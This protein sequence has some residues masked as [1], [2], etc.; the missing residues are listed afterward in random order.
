M[1]KRIYNKIQREIY[2][3]KIRKIKGLSVGNGLK[4]V[5]LPIIDIRNGGKISIGSNV[6]LT[7]DNVGYHLNMYSPVKLYA[8]RPGAEIV[9]G[10]NTRI[11]GSC[12]HAYEKISIGNNCLIA[13]NTQIMD[14]SGHDLSFENPANRINTTGTTKPVIIEDNVWIGANCI[15]L[16]GVTIGQGSIIG[17][18]SVVTKSIPPMVVAGGN[19]AKVIKVADSM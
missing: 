5:K 14:G 2:L 13:A 18:G 3:K 6:T 12:I 1:I 15:I 4:I 8:D 17:A 11:H 9:I 19:P 7:S 10:D 16:P